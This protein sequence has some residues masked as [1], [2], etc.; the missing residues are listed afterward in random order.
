MAGEPLASDLTTYHHSSQHGDSESDADAQDLYGPTDHDRTVLEEEE[1]HE[2]LMTGESHDGQGKR[3]SDQGLLDIGRRERRKERRRQRRSKKRREK[4]DRNEEGMLLYEMEEGG[5]RG[6]ACSLSSS[7]SLD[8]DRLAQQP[9]PSTKVC[10][11][12][13]TLATPVNVSLPS[14]GEVLATP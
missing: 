13:S 3:P 5:S 12:T 10:G 8:L 9:A 11:P 2:K 6:D 4:G 1:Q 7:S 14:A